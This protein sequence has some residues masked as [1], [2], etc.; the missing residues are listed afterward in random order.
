M[1]GAVFFAD[2]A[3]EAAGPRGRAGSAGF[4]GPGRSSSLGFRGGG[5]LGGMGSGALNESVLVGGVEDE[6]EHANE[7]EMTV[8]GCVWRLRNVQFFV[9]VFRCETNDLPRTFPPSERSI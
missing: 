7:S 1:T 8:G 2:L 6:I 3:A 9:E 4:I 5:D